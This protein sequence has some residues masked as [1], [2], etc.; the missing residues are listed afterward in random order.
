M[1]DLSPEHLEKYSKFLKKEKKPVQKFDE[2]GTAQTDEDFLQKFRKE[3]GADESKYDSSL[4]I[5]T[6]A[7]SDIKDTTEP[8]MEEPGTTP[9]PD[10]SD[11][12]PSAQDLHNS[13]G[14]EAVPEP[15]VTKAADDDKTEE[16]QAID[17]MSPEEKVQVEQEMSNK[18]GLDEATKSSMEG[19]V[20]EQEE[21]QP[22]EP[23][24]KPVTQQEKEDLDPT[25]T[26]S[27]P[28]ISQK[29]DVAKAIQDSDKAPLSYQEQLRQQYA[30]QNDNLRGIQIQKAMHIIASGILKQ[31]PNPEVY[32]EELA[33]AGQQ[34]KQF[35]DIYN[36]GKEDPNSDASKAARDAVGKALNID[37][38][39]NL[40]INA[41]EKL[42]PGLELPSKW[43]AAQALQQTKIQGQ[44]DVEGTKQQGRLELADTKGDIQ[45]DI[46]GQK[47]AVQQQNKQK[48]LA[49]QVNQQKDQLM[50]MK[51]YLGK[52]ERV[53]QDLGRLNSVVSSY[54]NLDSVPPEIAKEFET[55]FSV[56][57][58]VGAGSDA[59]LKAM[60][61]KNVTNEK[62]AVWE[63]LSSNPTGSE[64]GAWIKEFQRSLK[65]QAQAAS[66]QVD[67]GMIKFLKGVEPAVGRDL[68]NN[69]LDIEGIDQ[70]DYDNFKAGKTKQLAVNPQQG[71]GGAPQAGGL[72]QKPQ[73]GPGEKLL[74]SPSTKAYWIQDAQGNKRKAP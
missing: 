10:T 72:P 18:E 61:P 19:K 3:H 17:K 47:A 16:E 70:K 20:P 33:A 31:K 53:I 44:K 13:L 40:S 28:E 57:T 41:L 15:P 26:Q 64:Q 51:G 45:K 60:L 37:L 49:L 62:N 6:V 8:A 74:Y 27:G 71:T 21:A 54:P 67:E 48:Q 39:D 9:L 42:L 43:L 69:H 14:E 50:A 4:D 59:R 1:A 2:G 7:E 73:V 68:V 58:G 66:D 11:L 55:A 25:D 5:P 23:Q 22:E 46:A 56:L 38:P 35:E 32:N 36:A 65:S 12:V 34:V 24:G 63:W 52:P 30:Q 29:I